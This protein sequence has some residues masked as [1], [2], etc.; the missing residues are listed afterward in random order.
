M[1]DIQRIKEDR[2]IKLER[3]GIKR[4]R[5]PIRLLIKG[6]PRYQTPV[7]TV[8]LAVEVPANVKG[9]HMSRFTSI[10]HKY[11]DEIHGQRFLEMIRDMRAC[12]ESPYAYAKFSFPYYIEKT[13]PVSRELGIM[14]YP[15]EFEGT[16]RGDTDKLSLSVSVPITTLCPCSKAISEM[17]AHNQRADVT[18]TAD[19]SKELLWIEDIIKAV[20]DSASAPVYSLLKRVDEKFVTEQAYKNPQF[21]EDVVRETYSRI[22]ELYRCKNNRAFKIECESYESIH[23]HSAFASTH[24]STSKQ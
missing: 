24:Y 20:E 2:G 9:T 15:C 21:V 1:I 4:L 23:N 16:S 18:V 19:I 6:E 22:E 11:K 12:L 10:L 8:C 7:A 14:E 5:Y 13:A 17:G 3:V